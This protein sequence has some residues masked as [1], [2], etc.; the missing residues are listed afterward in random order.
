[1]TET[2]QLQDRIEELEAIIERLGRE[3]DNLRDIL[4][5]GEE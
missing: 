1:M 2:E 3:N 5:G 4:A